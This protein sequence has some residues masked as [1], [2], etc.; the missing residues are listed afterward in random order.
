MLELD[1]KGL[2]SHT[3]K[4]IRWRNLQIAGISREVL[5]T[6]LPSQDCGGGWETRTGIVKI[7]VIE[8]IR[9]Q[10]SY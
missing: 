3:N 9:S 1:E 4:K 8:T 5:R 10:A 7:V 2:A 6:K